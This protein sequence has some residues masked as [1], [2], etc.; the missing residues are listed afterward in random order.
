MTKERGVRKSRKVGERNRGS[1]G[2]WNGIEFV[3]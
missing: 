2:L 1:E 3:G